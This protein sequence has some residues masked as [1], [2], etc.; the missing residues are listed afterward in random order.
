MP[1][2][3]GRGIILCTYTRNSM[4]LV[5]ESLAKLLAQEDLIVEHRDV[6]TAQFEVEK[7]ILTLPNWKHTETVVVDA[8]ISHEVGHALY[9]P[10]DWSWEGEVPMQFV[11]VCEDVRI[12]KLMKRR[13]PGIPKTFFAGYKVLADEDFFK[14]AGQDLDEFNI[15]D[16]IN[17][18]Y[19]IGN[20]VD[21]PFKDE[22]QEFLTKAD[23]LE[24]FEDALALAKE[25]YAYSKAELDKKN[26]EEAEANAEARELP[27]E[28]QGENSDEDGKEE[29]ESNAPSQ[30][31]SE[32]G[33][34]EGEGGEP[35]TTEGFGD[36]D[37]GRGNG[38]QDAQPQ[39]EPT[40]RTMDDLVEGIK[41]L[42]DQQ[43][44]VIDYIE[45]PSKISEGHFISNKEVSDK[46]Q[47]YYYQKEQLQYQKDFEDDYELMMS[48]QFTRNLKQ[49]DEDYRKF[50]SQSTKE[51]SYLV[52]EFECKKAADSYART[53]VSRTGVID[54]SKLH[55]YKYNEDL[56]RKIS[57]VPEGKNHGLIFNIDWSGSMHSCI[58]DVIKQVLN[59]VT[60]CR[61][62]GIQYEVYLFS[63]AYRTFDSQYN[64]PLDNE[65]KVVIQN[66]TQ[67][68][69]LNSKS[70]NRQH[71]QQ[72]KNL[73]RL[74]SGF[75]REWSC[76]GPR[77]LTLG[78]T[79][80][81]ESMVAMNVILPRFK[82]NT[83]CQKVHVI[84]LTDGEGFPIGFGKAVQHYTTGEKHIIRRN[85]GPTTRLRDRQTGRQYSFKGDHYGQT[86]TWIQ[87]LRDRHP[88]CEFMNIRLLN[89]N[90][91]NR[92]KRGCLSYDMEEWARADAEWKKTRSFICLSSA[93][94]VQ[95]ALSVNALNSDA[96]FEV[97]EDAK[98]GD[99]TRAF[100]KSL[101]SK[102]MNKKILSSFIERIA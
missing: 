73:F 92:F 46:L 59:L 33:E 70:N 102:K 76:G 66:F 22:E 27:G 57:T 30:G 32:E 4:N 18:Q 49:I 15:A 94:T 100:K 1:L 48:R 34:S 83:G 19:K 55:T 38:P 81:N 41:Q 80:L 40:V 47:N 93:Y 29:M 98:K 78:G 16:R 43:A 77:E 67:I 51:V 58:K 72:A 5:K 36:G 50:K 9:T 11:N 79:P 28:G 84:N 2:P 101:A 87:Q 13:Y 60:F 25:I 68:N 56:F 17:L 8:L 37:V 24:T 96:E 69:V 65:A 44:D 62:V 74:V 54:T 3:H 91:W 53:T 42:V 86:D 88:D 7:R 35:E 6:D 26:K 52:K 12:E 21:V 82:K 95:Y 89:G 97:K 39:S 85:C 14:V 45:L 75:S 71:E 61:K 99:I 23:K 63:D 90:E 10:N 64:I 31:Q 20:F